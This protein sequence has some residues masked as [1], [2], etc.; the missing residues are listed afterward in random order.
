MIPLREGTGPAIESPDRIAA[1]YLGQV[2]GAKEPF[3][4]DLRQG[5]GQFSIGLG[6]VITGLG[7]GPGRTEGGCPG[8][9]HQPTRARPTAATGQPNIPANS[10]LVFVVDV[11]GVG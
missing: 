9:A 6:G 10:T 8:D 4:D 5:A 2:W 11:L 1:D 7:Q 3:E